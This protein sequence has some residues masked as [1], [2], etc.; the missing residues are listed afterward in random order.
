MEVYGL[1]GLDDCY[2]ELSFTSLGGCVVEVYGSVGFDSSGCVLSFASSVAM[3]R[4]RV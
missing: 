2:C 4:V 3:A 1:F